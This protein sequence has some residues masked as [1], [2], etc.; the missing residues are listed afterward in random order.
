MGDLAAFLDEAM[1]ARFS[2]GVFDCL[3]FPANWLVSCGRPDPAIAYRGRYQTELGWRRLASRAG[4][5]GVLVE[6][7]MAAGGFVPTSAAVAG[8]VGLVEVTTPA[9]AGPA[10]AIFTGAGWTVLRRGGG[11][12]CGPYPVLNAWSADCR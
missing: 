1:R 3:L 9:G 10:G 8:D 4:G 11:L 7:E 2:P 5:L 12:T 6:R